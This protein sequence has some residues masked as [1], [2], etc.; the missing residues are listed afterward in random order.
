MKKDPKLIVISAPSGAG[1][2]TLCARL[3]KE[4]DSLALSVSSTTRA[5]RGSEKEGVEYHFLSKAQFEEKI[6]LGHFAEHALVHGNFYGTSRDAIEK[7]WKLGKN[8]L[9]DIDVQGAASL[10]KAYPDRTVLIFISPPSLTALEARLR[11][12]ATDSEETIQR[13]LKNAETEMAHLLHFD[14]VI[15]NDDLDRAYREL[16][17][18]IENELRN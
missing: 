2:T 10:R 14:H 13:R 17:A 16:H 3:L 8:V 4:V 1:K 15:I 5:P 7:N 12:R 11:S 9:L 6:K 18:L